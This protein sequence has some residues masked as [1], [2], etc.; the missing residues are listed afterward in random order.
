MSTGT[1]IIHYH[2]SKDLEINHLITPCHSIIMHLAVLLYFIGVLLFVVSFPSFAQ[3][4]QIDRTVSLGA[5]H[6]LTFLGET[7]L[8]V[9]LMQGMKVLK[10]PMRTL[11]LW[12]LAGIFI[13]H[14]TMGI[15]N[16]T[17]TVE[18]PTRYSIP[19]FF[20]CMLP[21]FI[22]GYKI[23]NTY[24]GTLSV[25]GSWMLFSV[26][27]NLIYLLIIEFVGHYWISDF[28][29]AT[30]GIIYIIY[31]RNRLIGGEKARDISPVMNNE[32]SVTKPEFKRVDIP[33]TKPL[34][35]DETVNY[36]I[37]PAN[38]YLMTIAMLLFIIAQIMFIFCSPNM[39]RE[40][41]VNRTT[42]IIEVYVIKA[43]C[44][45]FL[46]Y[47]LMR[48]MS[49]L[50]YPLRKLFITTIV[51][52][53]IFNASVAIL[54]YLSTRDIHI[55]GKVYLP[56]FILRT[57]PYAALAFLIY[58]NYKGDLSMLGIFMM[59]YLAMNFL[60]EVFNGMGKLLYFDLLMTIIAAAYIF[61]LRRSLVS[62]TTYQ[63]QKKL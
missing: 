25:A 31:L 14:A 1:R 19:L 57:I 63:Q 35:T 53:F 12:A 3:S 58:K 33:L 34:K 11:F 22:L 10:K 45:T 38:K 6:V 62:E 7:T 5:A 9:C 59:V 55:I 36:V 28:I 2:S 48:G 26:A 56:L 37:A 16:M 61:I 44:E 47:C 54:A 20:V 23:D 8:L 41:G 29:C 42:Y 21:Y 13:I 46:L 43:I 60:M 52:V 50:K 18:I 32:D 49:V 15:L 24:Y 40:Y 17:G 4:H 51:F 27:L 30:V 39:A